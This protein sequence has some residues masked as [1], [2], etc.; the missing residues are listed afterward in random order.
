MADNPPRS[1][2][3]CREEPCGRQT[4]LLLCNVFKTF[5]LISLSCSIVASPDIKYESYRITFNYVVPILSFS[6][7]FVNPI[8]I[9]QGKGPHPACSR[10]RPS[11][12][13]S[14]SSNYLVMD[15]NKSL[16]GHTVQVF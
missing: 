11:G 12:V 4:F 14:L 2:N 8:F 15:S 9:F 10:C 7:I 16:S 3:R 13:K 5:A 1:V 6:L